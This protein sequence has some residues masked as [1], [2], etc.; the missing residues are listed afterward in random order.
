MPQ[1]LTTSGPKVMIGNPVGASRRITVELGLEKLPAGES[2][3]QI[4][5]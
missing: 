4:L 5:S 3:E 2:V 1:T